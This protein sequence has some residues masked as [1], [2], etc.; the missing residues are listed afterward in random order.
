MS[1]ANEDGYISPECFRAYVS[2]E[3]KVPNTL[4]AVG[5][6]VGRAA[7]ASLRP[8]DY[9]QPAIKRFATTYAFSPSQVKSA[10]RTVVLMHRRFGVPVL[11][12]SADLQGDNAIRLFK[13]QRFE[14]V[15]MEGVM[16]ILEAILRLHGE[17]GTK[18][19]PR[20]SRV[21]ELLEHPDKL[22]A[23]VAAFA[24]AE[25]AINSPAATERSEAFKQIFNFVKSGEKPR[26]MAP[27]DKDGIQAEVMPLLVAAVSEALAECKSTTS[28]DQTEEFLRIL[29]SPELH[30]EAA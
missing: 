2:A 6:Y 22:A 7:L 5:P 24:A 26:P 11:P 23:T 20:D 25:T 10:V 19:C 13:H 1:E 29:T 27:A 21:A 3:I 16:N 17:Q 8:G 14:V 30:E 9:F 4:I 18:G 12:E 15:Y 28:H